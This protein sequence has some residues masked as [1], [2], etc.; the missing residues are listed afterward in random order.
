[1]KPQTEVLLEG[2]VF[3]EAPRWHE[4]KLWFADMH[5][6]HVSTV[7][8]KGN[9]NRIVDVPGQP[10]GLGWLPGGELLVVSMID[11]RLLRL[12][13]KALR[14][15]ADLSRL[16]PFHCNDM[17]VDGEGRAYIGNFGFDISGPDPNVTSTV[18]ILVS[19]EGQAR[20]VAQ[21]LLFPNGLIIT[22]DAGTLIVGETWGA[23][24][25]AFTIAA[26][27]SLTDRRVWAQLDGAV[28]DGICL[29]A[30]GAVWVAS[31]LSAEVL[32][33]REGGEI[34]DCIHVATNAY[35]CMLGGSERKSLFV[36]TAAS[37][38]PEEARN[39]KSGRI[40]VVEVQVPGAG[41]P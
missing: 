11:R 18:L 16:A 17:V 25:T 1:M 3:P 4:G 21:D 30:E 38:Q 41:L 13:A 19:S 34:T 20:I 37:H 39:L 35:A 22:P 2:L 5:A 36:L 31:P 27:G 29:D 40:E 12:D 8:L 32:R 6:H 28:P 33:V 24:L 14:A 26:D 10:G 15:V 9:V 23:R 7:D